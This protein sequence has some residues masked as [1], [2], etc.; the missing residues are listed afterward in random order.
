MKESAH[1]PRRNRQPMA[2]KLLRIACA[3]LACSVPAAIAHMPGA[4]NL[5]IIP[6]PLSVHVT[7]E[8]FHL[9]ANV[10]LAAAKKDAGA[11]RAAAFLAG[12]VKRTH[13]F[14]LKT[15][16]E[17]S[18][19]PT[20]RFLRDAKFAG[21]REAYRIDATPKGASII[22]GS[23]AGLLYG[24][25]SL[26]QSLDREGHVPAMRIE[27][28]PRFA[29]R[30]LMLDS[31]RHYQSPEF[32]RRFIDAMA[33]HKLNVLHWHLTDDQAWRLEIKR[34]PDLTRVGAWRVP[35]GAAPQSDVDPKTGKPRL[36]G[37]FYSQQTVRE[38][39]RYAADRGIAIIPEID[40][41]GHASATLAAYPKLGATQD[42]PK[43]V[44]ADWGIYPNAFN[45]DE[46]TFVFLQDVLK[47][48]M[49]LFPGR[50]IHAGGDEVV[51]KQW[52]ES[53]DVQR[54]M[55][56]LGIANA[57][58]L[59]TYFTQRIARFLKSH[60][61][62]LVGWDEILEPGIP[63]G[64][65][66]MSWRGVEGALKAAKEGFDTVLSPWPAMYFDNLQRFSPDEPPGRGRLISL[67]DVYD[68]EPMPAVLEPAQRKH[69]LGLQANI[70]TEHIRTEERAAH[71]A[72]PR[73]AAVA[74]LG[75]SAPAR[76]DW[77]GFVGRLPKLMERYRAMGL[78]YADSAFAV[79]G[80][81]VSG[82]NGARV[83]L[84]TQSGAGQIRYTLDGSA[85]TAQSALYAG[86]LYLSAQPA[87][88]LRA[89][90]FIDGKAVSAPRDFALGR[91]A[92]ARR[93]SQ[94]LKLCTE[95][96]ALSLEDDAPIDGK[97][98]AMLADIGNPCWIYRGLDLAGLRGM[99][100]AVGQVPFNF[101]I[102]ED[103]HK[104]KFAVP[105]TASGELEVHADTCEG[106]V[107]ARLSLAP[108]VASQ[109][110][111]VLPDAAFGAPA[112]GPAK[113]DLCFKFA[114]RF[115][116]WK[117]DP[118]WVLDWVQPLYVEAAR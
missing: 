55:R 9:S 47:E 118:V 109:A 84:A 20:I 88:V 4:P 7:G 50:Y 90:L 36:Y 74:E 83:K 52:E 70:W 17:S 104:I 58:A 31:A 105:Q 69:V 117:S 38:L 114:Q 26:W 44:P 108:A 95:N 6:A 82:T 39:V 62:Q 110:V 30:G 40:L 98:A 80:E 63:P 2:V 85:P 54:R 99:R 57:A 15:V 100:A 113:R 60:G 29:W 71:M 23:D 89:A 22:A 81:V 1:R 27:D 28:A 25:V 18:S 111:T 94:Q 76:R 19:Q 92:S 45:V 41:P 102:G 64:S 73:A 103:V 87:G 42:P 8:G 75:W 97:R 24:A 67:K 106:P 53:P 32:I 48:V 34:Y 66:V 5:P 59:Q 35:A 21:G 96:I 115:D 12:L 43:S 61:R 77:R 49:D 78:P 93:S 56:E 14:E 91:E 33:I 107:L 10:A 16:S 13:G 101:Q 51:K 116:N 11:K 65:T 86:E 68:F 3:S 37:G 72:F 112:D 79:D 46:S